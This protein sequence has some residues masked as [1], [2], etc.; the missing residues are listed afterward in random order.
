[1]FYELEVCCSPMMWGVLFEFWICCMRLFLFTDALPKSWGV[2]S[3]FHAL[4][5]IT[6]ASPPRRPAMM[7]L[8]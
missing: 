5:E 7:L 6:H 8:Q 2:E 4:L 3:H 1:M